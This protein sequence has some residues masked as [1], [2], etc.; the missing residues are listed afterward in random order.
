MANRLALLIALP[1]ALAG[2]CVRPLGMQ[3]AANGCQSCHVPRHPARGPCASC[4]RGDP[5]AERKELAHRRLLTGRAAEH[6][7]PGSRAVAEGR[8]EVERLACRRCHTIDG[9][10]NRLATDLGRVA[11]QRDQAG[12]VRSIGD[13]AWSMPRFGLDGR[14]TEAVVAYLLQGAARGAAVATYRVRFSRRGDA[15]DSV[16]GLKCGGCHR[17]I[18]VSG[19]SGR[20][21]AGPDLSGLFT[22]FYPASA[23]DRGRWR[24]SSLG[25]WLRNP[26]ALRS[27]TTM[28]PVPLEPSAFEDLV[29][30]LDG[31]AISI[32]PSEQGPEKRRG[33]M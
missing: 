13:P 24:A 4:H 25:R 28:R 30:E 3:R 16:F 11:W 10:G 26:R 29:E 20:G 14:K 18:T 19:P 23:P 7:S 32:A 12:L 22:S 6:G 9:T 21:S 17:S 2:G 8:R 15:R 5:A 27:C 31:S 1:L 33:S